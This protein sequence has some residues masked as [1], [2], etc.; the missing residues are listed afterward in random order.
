MSTVSFG[1]NGTICIRVNVQVCYILF[2]LHRQLY[3]STS[4]TGS[5]MSG[6][7]RKIQTKAKIM[8]L[9]LKSTLSTSRLVKAIAMLG[10]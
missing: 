2:D 7:F 4:T 1:Q 6:F 10:T 9:W 5:S 3:L 8:C